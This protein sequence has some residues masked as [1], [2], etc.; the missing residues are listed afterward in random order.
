MKKKL[1]IFLIT[2]LGILLILFLGGFIWLKTSTYSASETAQ[3]IAAQAVT[4]NGDYYYFSGDNRQDTAII[5]FLGALVDS[6]SYAT[7]AQDTA[8]AGYDVY[9]LKVPFDLAVL[10]GNKPESILEDYPQKKF[11]L[12]GHSLGGV[13]ASRFAAQHSQVSGLILMASYPDEKGS[14]KDTKLPV[15]SITAS[16]DKVLNWE[17]YEDA[18]KFL[19]VTTVYETI[20]GGNHGG[21]GSYGFQKGDG[22]ASISTEQQQKEIATMITRWLATT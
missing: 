16:Q 22:K 21:F 5:F 4:E 18:K 1:K 15:L 13:M 17:N 20:Q 3:N 6:A 19:P 9:L 8:E 11:I 12:S 7:W 2:L 14:L 10:A